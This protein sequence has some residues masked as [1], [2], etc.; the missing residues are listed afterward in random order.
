M[1]FLH[2]VFWSSWCLILAIALWLI[3]ISHKSVGYAGVY[4]AS[5][6]FKITAT[7]LSPHLLISPSPYQSSLANLN[8]N[9]F[10]SPVWAVSDGSSV[11]RLNSGL[12]N[13]R[14]Q[15]YQQALIDFTDVIN[16]NED[17]VG[18]AY[19]DRCLVNLQLQQYNSAKSDCLAALEYD[20][21][22]KEAY[23]NLG[24]SYYYLQEYQQAIAQYR[25]VIKRDRHDYRAYYNLG[26]SHSA[27]KDY[28]QAKSDYNL[29]LMS[30]DS[31]PTERQTLIY[32]ERGIANIM[33]ANYQRAI[34]D[35]NQAIDLKASNDSAYFNR[36]CAHHQQ[37]NYLAAIDDFTQVVQLNPSQTQA[38]VNR[39]IL[40][41]QLRQE[42]A[43]FKDLDIALQQYQ[44]QGDRAAYQQILNLQQVMIQ[45]QATQIA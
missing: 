3:P 31:I 36:G 45:S 26:L 22:N 25:Q 39:A 24:L 6:N 23:L 42:R 16:L 21:D 10:T 17:L 11:A 5:P 1:T 15:N 38:Y 44:Q 9:S 40:H 20:R 32:N 34:A 29:A 30:S 19:S 37:G 4:S 12:D 18:A 35:L 8:E 28:Q 43:A 13:V 7:N 27:L 2:R 33:L 14:Q 41:H